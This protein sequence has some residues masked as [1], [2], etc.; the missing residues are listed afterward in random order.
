MGLAPFHNF[1]SEVTDETKA[2]L[3]KIKEDII[4]GTIKVETAGSPTA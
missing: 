2:E 4:S 1:D 3:D